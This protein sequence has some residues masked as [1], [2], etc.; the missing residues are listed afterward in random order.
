MLEVFDSFPNLKVFE[1]TSRPSIGFDTIILIPYSLVDLESLD[2]IPEQVNLYV[3]CPPS[4]L[5][6]IPQI[7]NL[8]GL[9]LWSQWEEGDESD[10]DFGLLENHRELR[11]LSVRCTPD[12][13]EHIAK[14]H[15]LR[16]L[17]LLPGDTTSFNKNLRYLENLKMLR[18]LQLWYLELDENGLEDLKSLKQLRELYLTTSSI[19]NEQGFDI[20]SHLENLTV[21]SLDIFELSSKGYEYLSGLT[22]LRELRFSNGGIEDSGFTQICT[23]NGLKKLVLFECEIN[24]P[25]LA[26]LEKLTNLRH[27]ELENVGLAPQD[28][29]HLDKLSNLEVLKLDMTAIDQ[30]GMKVIADLP[31]L[32][33]F[34]VMAIA[35]PE[36]AWL[37]L[38]E[39][40]NLKDLY[41]SDYYL[42]D[43]TF[44]KLRGILPDCEV[45]AWGHL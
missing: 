36:T 24:N 5:K 18:T 28:L 31:N 29:R 38:G 6:E 25:E 11:Q 15:K 26:C 2:D 12:D 30:E 21:L 37:L 35:N 42:S 27:L 20:F 8:K 33:K 43:S 34:D 44:Q 17:G 10:I 13:L 23:L 22:N 3:H 7:P 40:K 39:C 32:R 41:L 45:K 1:I 19:Q 14:L 4:Q 9:F 16:F